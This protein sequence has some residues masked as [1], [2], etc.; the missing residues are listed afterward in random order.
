MELPEGTTYF[1]IMHDSYDTYALYLDDFEFETAP[2]IPVDTRHLGY[3]LYRD[4]VMLNESPIEGTSYVDAPASEAATTTTATVSAQ[5]TIMQ[6]H[7]TAPG[8]G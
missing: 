8:R 3:N 4:G 6:S 7:A 2:V 5:P 1:A